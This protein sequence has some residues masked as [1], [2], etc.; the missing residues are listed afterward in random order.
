MPNRFHALSSGPLFRFARQIRDFV[1][2][3]W[4]HPERCDPEVLPAGPPE[5]DASMLYSSEKKFIFVHIYKTG[6]ESVVAA[7]RSYC[8]LY[9]RD[10]Y[11]NKAIRVLPSPS[12]MLIGWRES[13]VRRQHMTAEQIR[14]VMPAEL[15]N[16]STRFAFVRNPWDWH[17]SMYH[18]ATQS[19]AHPRHEEVKAIGGFENYIRWRCDEGISLQ[20][21]YVFDSTGKKI[22]DEVGRFETLGAD[23]ERICA[24]MGIDARL[25]HKNASKRK[26]DW[27]SYYNDE[28]HDL[29]KTTYAKDIEAFGYTDAG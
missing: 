11:V 18:Y 2:H 4:L 27:R 17:V 5:L 28:T 6:G 16:Q 24:G 14:N 19:K 10:R 13:A 23:F 22:V 20:S 3:C 8:P 9:F 29:I 15:F 1:N 21:A 26:K 12:R 25:P 7:L